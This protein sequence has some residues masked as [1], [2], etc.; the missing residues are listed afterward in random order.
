M[1]PTIAK[2]EKD[3]QYHRTKFVISK[4]IVL[5]QW[6]KVTV[7]SFQQLFIF[8]ITSS[9]SLRYMLCS[10]NLLQSYNA[11]STRE[12]VNACKKCFAFL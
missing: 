8:D 6:M 2:M 4:M 9:I 12:K 1:E 3:Q 10:D 11:R 5:M 7:V